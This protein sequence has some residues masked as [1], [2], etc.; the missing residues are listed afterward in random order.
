MTLNHKTLTNI[1]KATAKNTNKGYDLYIEAEAVDANDTRMID[2]AYGTGVVYNILGRVKSTSLTK[3]PVKQ[4]KESCK[5]LE[6]Q[7]GLLTTAETINKNEY[8]YKLA[9]STI[10][11]VNQALH[12][13]VITAEEVD[14]ELV[15][16]AYDF[17]RSID[18]VYEIAEQLKKFASVKQNWA[19]R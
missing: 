14:Y 18:N 4:L 8:T 12:L 19:G 1:T 10:Q 9:Y 7:L 13:Y 3:D 11:G 16:V 6:K 17:L 5:I 2:S 15:Q